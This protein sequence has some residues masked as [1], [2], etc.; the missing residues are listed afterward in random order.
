MADVPFIDVSGAFMLKDFVKRAATRGIAVI[1]TSVNK[2]TKHAL[3]KMSRKRGIYGEFIDD[4]EQAIERAYELRQ[5]QKDEN[6]AKNILSI[7]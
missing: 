3:W 4:P 7:E 1:L 5:Q 6:D 2:N